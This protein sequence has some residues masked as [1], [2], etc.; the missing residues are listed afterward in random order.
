MP[1]KMHPKVCLL[2]GSKPSRDEPSWAGIAQGHFS[3]SFR[4]VCALVTACFLGSAKGRISSIPDHVHHSVTC[5]FVPNPWSRLLY[6]RKL[7]RSFSDFSSHI[8]LVET[9]P[10]A[11]LKEAGALVIL[12]GYIKHVTYMRKSALES[13]YQVSAWYCPSHRVS[14]P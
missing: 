9:H 2:G 1:S 10:A 8:I 11:P 13:S 4:T 14:M 3:L 6:L 5:A 7:P 12:N